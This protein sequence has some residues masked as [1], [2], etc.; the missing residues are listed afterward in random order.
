MPD[1]MEFDFSELDTLAAT[2][3]GA[4][5][6]VEDFI[7]PAF[8]KTSRNIRDSWRDK[9][10]GSEMLPHLGRAITWQV[11]KSRGAVSAEIGPE[12]GRQQAAFAHLSEF[13][14]TNN[15]GRGYGLRALEENTDDFIHGLNEAVSDALKRAGL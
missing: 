4:A 6:G 2:L 8:H 11:N 5:D 1:S 12:R 7:N 10:A 13:G 9:L 14:S 15:P 3:A